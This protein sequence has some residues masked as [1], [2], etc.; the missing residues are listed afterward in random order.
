MSDINT[1]TDRQRP[2]RKQLARLL[3]AVAVVCFVGAM[4]ASPILSFG[5]TTPNSASVATPAASP[6]PVTANGTRLAT[7]SDEMAAKVRAASEA[8]L[9]QKQTLIPSPATVVL[10]GLGMAAMF[11]RKRSAT[12]AAV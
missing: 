11:R 8:D 12:V 4:L 5:F 1:K 2:L 9:A 7:L 10:G 6:A 3:P